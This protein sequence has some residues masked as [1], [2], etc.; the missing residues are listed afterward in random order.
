MRVIKHGVLLVFAVSGNLPEEE[1]LR[2]Y[3]AMLLELSLKVLL[4]KRK[5]ALRGVTELCI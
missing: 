4:E 5:A 3:C 2:D 1:C